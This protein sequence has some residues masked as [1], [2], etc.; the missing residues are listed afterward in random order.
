M[1]SWQEEDLRISHS[2]ERLL[3]G[4]R[5]METSDS[6]QST[7]ADQ[8][9]PDDAIKKTNQIFPSVIKHH[10]F[11]KGEGDPDKDTSSSQGQLPS[12]PHQDTF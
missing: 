2:L 6:N 7:R 4:S 8:A 9:I 11:P 10:L 3:L 1:M 12:H 5:L